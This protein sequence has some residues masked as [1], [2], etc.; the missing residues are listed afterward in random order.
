M[1]SRAPVGSEAQSA[2]SEEASDHS[3]GAY[4]SVDFAVHPAHPPRMSWHLLL[5]LSSPL[6]SLRPA[7]LRDDRDRQ[8]LALRQQLPI[9]QRQLGKPPRLSR[10]EK[11]AMLLATARTKQRQVP[12]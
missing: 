9:L 10:A 2:T 7:L 8:I 5:A 1:S 3:H 12:T 11:L 6:A 4:P